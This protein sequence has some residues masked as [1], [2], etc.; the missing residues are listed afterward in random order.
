MGEQSSEK[1]CRRYWN[2]WDKFKLW[3][4]AEPYKTEKRAIKY[5]IKL[6]TGKYKVMCMR[7]KTVLT[8]GI[9]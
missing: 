1:V 6:T 4:N 7:K 9:E 2:T 8:A 5:Q 3:V